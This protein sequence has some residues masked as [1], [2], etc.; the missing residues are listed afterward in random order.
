MGT[1]EKVFKNLRH[2]L[3]RSENDE[4]FDSKTNVLIWSQKLFPLDAG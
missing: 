4:M 1:H 2:K 3:C